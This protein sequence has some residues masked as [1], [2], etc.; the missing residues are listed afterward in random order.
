MGAASST[1]P[2][3]TP[4]IETDASCTSAV[5]PTESEQLQVTAALELVQSLVHTATLSVQVTCAVQSKP[6]VLI[7]AADCC[8]LSLTYP[9]IPPTGGVS[10]MTRYL[11]SLLLLVL[12]SSVA[13]A[14]TT[15]KLLPSD[16]P[17]EQAVD[18]YIGAKLKEAKITP[19]PRAIFTTTSRVARW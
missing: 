8:I 15:E 6:K 9:N 12:G 11:S 5:I 7:L 16:R 3:S 14:Q 18:Y 13:F 19:A 4:S 1:S 2:S 17:I 10:A